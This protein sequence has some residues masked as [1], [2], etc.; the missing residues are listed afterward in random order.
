VPDPKR[1]GDGLRILNGTFTSK[2]VTVPFDYQNGRVTRRARVL[3]VFD[4]SIL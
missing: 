2:T 1:G 4:P 3:L